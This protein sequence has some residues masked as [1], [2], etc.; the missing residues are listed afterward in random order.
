MEQHGWAVLHN[1]SYLDD[2]EGHNRE[3]DIRGYRQWSIGQSGPSFTMGVY[4]I[5]E[6]KKS[7][8]P[9]VFFT[10]PEEQSRHQIAY[11]RRT[12]K[13]QGNP[14]GLFW[15]D[16]TESQPVITWDYMRALHHYY[17]LPNRARTFHEPFKGKEK[18]EQH[19]QTIYS[20][21]S[22][23]IKA[24][25]FHTQSGAYQ[26]HLL[27]YYPIVIYSGNLFTAQ[28][29]AEKGI[30]LERSEYIQLAYHYIEAR[31]KGHHDFIVDIV[32]E[33]YL[34]D[35]L[36]LLYEEHTLLAEYLRERLPASGLH[37]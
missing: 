21:V 1:P 33:T 19:S 35:F 20:A 13:A 4:L 8:K 23:A 30:A 11:N 32:R 27:I 6:C 14:S 36:T 29:N 15:T 3:F 10:T 17:K 34:D 16:S 25:L 12:I 18:G 9:W 31:Q 26:G 7:D 5:A 28:V 37:V 22:S 2:V 24:T